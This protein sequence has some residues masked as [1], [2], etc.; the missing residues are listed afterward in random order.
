MRYQILLLLLIP[1]LAENYVRVESPADGRTY[2]VDLDDAAFQRALRPVSETSIA[3]M[4]PKWLY[5]GAGFKPSRPSWDPISGIVRGTFAA[6]GSVE[7][8]SAFYDQAL[9]SQ[10]LRVSTLPYKG[11]PGLQMTGSGP[12]TTVT[13]Q[14]QPQ[15][16]SIQIITT[17]AP[18]SA[19]RRHFEVVW[20]D[21]QSGLLRVRD[22]ATGVDYQMD[23]AS[24]VS[25]NLNRP[26]AV[27]SEGAAMPSW[28]RVYPGAAGSP[29][30]R[31]HW[32]FTPTAEFVTGDPIRKVYDFYL[33]QVRSAGAT[34][35]SSGMNR[36]GKPLK[37]SDAYVVALKG[38]DEVEI[39]IGE[40]IQ[41]GYPPSGSTR[42]TGIG[43]R[44]TVPK[45]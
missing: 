14:I 8:I 5:P 37:D 26:G 34:V 28:L 41:I 12:A 31:I 38:D 42:P 20:Y 9:R 18:K 19:P 15:A 1:G 33:E 24:I 17:Y 32:L 2:T 6:G 45:R 16:G 11:S 25:N 13:V 40:V 23:K 36:S 7:Q 44:Y 4:L 3:A 22:T 39:R 27:A 30:G 43:I 21:D 29:K 35:K 10:G